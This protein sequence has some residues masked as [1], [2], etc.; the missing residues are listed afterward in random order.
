ME[1]RRRSV[2][3]F[4]GASTLISMAATLFCLLINWLSLV[5]EGSPFPAFLLAW[6]VP[7]PLIY[8]SIVIIVFNLSI[9]DLDQVKP[10]RSFM[11]ISLMAK[12]NG[13]F[14]K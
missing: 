9:S 5:N 2:F 12:D 1:S 11:W 10:R 8:A 13:H 4:G 14:K 7:L 3:R 6:S